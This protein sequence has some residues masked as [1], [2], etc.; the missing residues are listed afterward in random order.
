MPTFDSKQSIENRYQYM[1]REDAIA[2]NVERY[3]SVIALEAVNPEEIDISTHVYFTPDE[4]HPSRD[5]I[6]PFM[7]RA[8]WDNGSDYP[9]VMKNP[10]YDLRRDAVARL[11]RAMVGALGIPGQALR[12]DAQVQATQRAQR[13][14]HNAQIQAQAQALNINWVDEVNRFRG[15]TAQATLV[16]E[17]ERIPAAGNILGAL[18]GA[19]M[20]A[21]TGVAGMVTQINTTADTMQNT[22]Q[23][24]TMRRARLRRQ[25]GVNNN[26]TNLQDLIQENEPIV[27]RAQAYHPRETLA[28]RAAQNIDA[29]GVDIE[30]EASGLIFAAGRGLALEQGNARIIE[31]YTRDNLNRDQSNILSAKVLE[32]SEIRHTD[33][34]NGQYIRNRAYEKIN[35]ATA[36]VGDLRVEGVTDPTPRP[37]TGTMAHTRTAHSNTEVNELI[38]LAD[39]VTSRAV[40]RM[41]YE[42]GGEDVVER[43][44]TNGLTPD[45]FE[46]LKR[47]SYA[48]TEGQYGS[49]RKVVAVRKLVFNKL[50][51]ATPGQRDVA[52]YP[53]PRYDTL[54]FTQNPQGN[55]P[56]NA[57]VH[58]TMQANGQNPQGNA[59]RNATV[60]E[61]MQANGQRDLHIEIDATRLIERVCLVLNET[62]GSDI[63]WEAYLR[64]MLTYEQAEQLWEAVLEASRDMLWESEGSLQEILN[65]VHAK[66]EASRLEHNLNN[67]PRGDIPATNIE[68]DGN[69][70][71][72]NDYYIPTTPA[73][74]AIWTTEGPTAGDQPNVATA[75]RT[76]RADRDFLAALQGYTAATPATID[77]TIVVD[78][79]ADETPETT[80]TSAGTPRTISTPRPRVYMWSGPAAYTKKKEEPKVVRLVLHDD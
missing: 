10:Q 47:I 80:T 37:N 72:N 55:A 28:T 32:I 73:E 36:V 15:H 1:S 62:T 25:E 54:M 42:V 38:E 13:Q 39:E 48:L 60:Y 29:E 16:D 40:E 53:D 19:G 76:G 26:H 65:R 61:T 68:R 11:S 33:P 59:P 75:V 21:L 22:A 17:A 9:I 57:S 35:A 8:Q 50:E 14:N 67:I 12:S 46:R 23:N 70:N 6:M 24:T 49:H 41:S 27:R 3:L 20:A 56:R 78:G 4:E 64:D 58:E 71:Q 18:G 51:A 45:Q 66:I 77:N 2:S 74:G 5:T 30:T 43:Y 52:A 79:L 44:M 7:R 34:I 69:N 31:A 63:I